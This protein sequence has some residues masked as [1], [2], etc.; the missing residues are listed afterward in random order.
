MA[1]E[2]I[3]ADTYNISDT[4]NKLQKRFIDNVDSDTLMLGIFGY[5]NEINTNNLQ[6]SIMM[7]AEWGNEILPIKA[8]FEKTILTNAITYNIKNINAIPSTMRVM[9]GFIEKEL[10][11]QMVNNK[12]VLSKE[13][14]FMVGDYEFHLDYDLI[15]ASDEIAKEGTV[16]TC[17]YDIQRE[18]PLSDITSPYLDVPPIR[19]QQNND[20]FIFITCNIRQIST[21]KIYKKIISNNILENKTVDFNINE[22]MASFDVIIINADGSKVYL[23]PIYEGMPDS[24]KQFCYYNYLDSNTI[25][26]KFYTDSYDPPLNSTIEIDVHSTKGKDGNI[27]YRDDCI[28]TLSAEDKDYSNISV[29]IKPIEPAING[30]DKKTIEQLKQMIPKEML[31]RGSIINTKD[32]QNFFNNI[33]A[34]NRLMF[35]KQRDNQIERLYYAYLLAKD[36]DNNII[37]TN[38]LDV[39]I[40]E[41]LFSST[42]NDRFTIAPGT[43]IVYDG[44]KYANV[45]S[46]V[47]TSSKSKFIYASPF[48]IVVN[49]QPLSV[50]YYLDIIDTNYTLK[51]DYINQD[52]F[53]QFIATTLNCKKVYVESNKYKITT[54]ITQNVN[55][56]KLLVE[57]DENGNIIKCNLKPVLVFKTDNK[58]S[59]YIEGKVLSYDRTTFS[60][61]VEFI[62]DAD[63]TLNGNNHM[64]IKDVF[65]S[66]TDT[67]VNMY[68]PDSINT[69][70]YIYAKFDKSY[71]NNDGGMIPN[72]EDYTL[73]NRYSTIEGVHLFYNYSNIIKSTV[74]ITGKDPQKG[75]TF[76]ISGVPLVKRSYIQDGDRCINCAEYLQYR[77]AYI[78]KALETLENSFNIDMKFYNTYGPSKIFTIGYDGKKLDKVNLTLKFA[79]KL[80]TGADDNIL[81][82]IK[83]SIKTYVE[84][85]NTLVDSIHMNNLC[86]EIKNTYKTEIDFIEFIGINDYNALLQYIKKID[87]DELNTVPEF[88]CLNLSDNITSDIQIKTV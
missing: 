51:Y 46:E 10:K 70:L 26:I 67:K 41:D 6:N 44:G 37:P 22:D 19:M 52:S 47:N 38:T 25:R 15:I 17:R 66:G 64:R 81:Y 69:S 48:I 39:M 56:D 74:T 31:A 87:Y 58:N 78:D 54:K 82:H 11:S 9:I 72:M 35:F 57:T 8:K 86:T 49:K 28:Q 68:L 55:V 32:I 63:S 14:S 84:N 2:I 13:C 65:L 80:K 27:D 16:Y 18:N 75:S 79:I 53:V 43:P 34:E 40:T 1:N 7:A 36:E 3:S 12:F 29:L 24:T 21:E 83:S 85:I 42:E 73:C 71:G 4:I 61:N 33:D 20:T 23:E 30:Y 50:S 5:M 60:Y 77:K 45:R 88:L 76:N 62:L 59:Y